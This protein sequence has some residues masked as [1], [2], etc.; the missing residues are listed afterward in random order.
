MKIDEKIHQDAVEYSMSAIKHI[1]KNLPPRE[2]GSC[3]ERMAQEYLASDIT[4]NKWGKVTFEEFPVQPKAFMGFSK[5][6]PV[7]LVIGIVFYY[8]LQWAPLV[9]SIISLIIFVAQFGLYKKFLDPFYKTQTSSNL[10]AVKEAEKE[11]KKRIIF[12]GHAD[13]AY[14]WTI[15][16]KFGKVPFIGGLALAILGVL[17]TIAIS[18]VGLVV[19]FAWWQLIVMLVFLPGY[20][21]LFLFSNYKK[22]VQG[23]NDNLTGCLA[24]V[25]VL[26]YMKEAGLSFENTEVIAL[27]TGSEEAGLR[28]AKY[29]AKK[30]LEELTKIPTV[31]ISLET[32][33]DIDYLE[34]YTR[35]LSG[36]V[37]HHP[38]VIELID[39][40]AVKLFG[41][42]L[43]HSSVF[44]G[45]SDAAAI[46]QAGIPAGAIAAMDP[47]PASYYHT[48]KDSCEN[49]SPEC[50]SKGLRLALTIAYI[51]DKE[52]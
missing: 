15:F 35:D 25:S 48:R 42:P 50:F 1:C 49:L 33:R 45:A 2:S 4:N 46:T 41:K 12:S 24:S 17:S 26:K 6:I 8:W 32:F 29:F 40:A 5:I 44:L 31:F 11:P 43:K 27:V 16:N 18:I 52:Y 10:I 7:L 20:L 22:V 9:M 14:E 34:N 28:G 21:A 38:K 3:G 39:K 36:T 37:K 51:Y 13:A 30:H 47:S 23:A 19:G